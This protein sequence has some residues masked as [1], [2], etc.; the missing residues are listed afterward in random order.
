MKLKYEVLGEQQKEILPQLKFL[1]AEGF[2]LAGG[3]GMALQAGHRMS[4]DFDFYSGK[5]FEKEL[6]IQE[7]NDKKINSITVQI[8]AGTLIVRLEGVEVSFFFYPYK[9]LE[10][11]VKTENL[12]IA[13]LPDIAAMKLIAVIQRG[14]KRDFFDLY[15]LT[16]RGIG[17][18]KLFDLCENKY[19]SFNRYLAL[20]S[21]T[22]FKDAEEFDS[23]EG[24]QFFISIPWD[25]VKKYFLQQVK[26]YKNKLK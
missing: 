15:F 21:L 19:P 10:P 2:Y 4:L 13:S 24:R 3:T 17:L 8:S 14:I 9:L 12:N 20:Q 25:K 18:E 5:R 22:Y 6:L 7:I 16:T 23:L 11:L 1:K 26:K